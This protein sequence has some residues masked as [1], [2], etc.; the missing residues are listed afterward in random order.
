MDIGEEG[1]RVF[2]SRTGS[3]HR[4]LGL[5]LSAGRRN[6]RLPL[7]RLAALL[8]DKIISVWRKPIAAPFR[9]PVDLKLYPKYRSIVSHPISLAD[10]RN[11]IGRLIGRYVGR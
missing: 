10:I 1:R 6:M 11:N 5:G 4:A 3:T 8:E 9:L 2:G 7:M